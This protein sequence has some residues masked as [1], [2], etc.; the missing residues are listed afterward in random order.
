MNKLLTAV[1]GVTIG[2]VTVATSSS[3]SKGAAA[4]LPKVDHLVYGTPDLRVCVEQIERL[5]GVRATP[6][7]QHPGEGTRNPLISL[8]PAVYLECLGP[9]PE[10]LKPDRP[11][12]FGIDDLT[13]P[14]LVGWAAKGDDLAQLASN[15]M[16]NGIKLG[17]RW[18][19][20]AGKR[21]RA[22]S[23][24]GRSRISAQDWPTA[25]ARFLSTGG[26]TPH[27]ARTAAGRATLVELR[28]EH[29]DP[30]R[31]QK[32]LS[33]LGLDLPVT[34]AMRPALIATIA[35]PRGRVELR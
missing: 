12:W 20:G 29:P 21:H 3:Q 15:A 28:A 6:G 24:L 9:D 16:R 32:I 8:G 11:R 22:F 25:S 33:R 26:Q 1:F 34:K 27:P 23:L 30:E 17:E 18:C 10:Q 7:G 19:L 14:R 13:T 2:V 31:V 35:S 4:L 5:L